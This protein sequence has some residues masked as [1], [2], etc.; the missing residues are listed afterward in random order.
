MK[1][2]YVTVP[3]G[4]KT[5]GVPVTDAVSPTVVPSCTGEV[6]GVWLALTITVAVADVP[7]WT[8]SG[9]TGLVEPV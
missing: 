7:C 1:N 3:V 6:I 8:K 9:S 2:W 4:V 5:D